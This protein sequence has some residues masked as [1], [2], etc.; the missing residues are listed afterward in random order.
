MLTL[1]ADPQPSE[2]KPERQG[3]S[4]PR[5]L[6]R[7]LEPFPAPAGPVPPAFGTSFQDEGV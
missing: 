2:P 7:V 5:R 4:Q 3:P 6:L 1:P